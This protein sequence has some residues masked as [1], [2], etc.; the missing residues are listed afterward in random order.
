MLLLLLLLLL[1][2]SFVSVVVC[3]CE[4]VVV[5]VVDLVPGMV[6]CNRDKGIMVCPVALVK[7]C[8][9]GSKTCKECIKRA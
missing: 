9:S 4:V 8:K 7:N 5:V 3:G 1:L 2:L 6:N